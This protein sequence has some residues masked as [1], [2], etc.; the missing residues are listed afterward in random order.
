MRLT[1]KQVELTIIFS[2]IILSLVIL[3]LALL[4]N[5]G[6]AP[7]VALKQ[8]VP[9]SSIQPLDSGTHKEPVKSEPP[10][11]VYQGLLKL[12]G[13]NNVKALV[14]GDSV[15]ESQGATNRE[16]TSWYTLVAN[17]L[18][19]KYPGTVQWE[20]KTTAEAKIHD[21]LNFVPDVPR[22][23]DIIVL[24]VGRYDWTTL[25]TDDF[26]TSYEQV[27]NQLKLN[28][29]N[30]NIFLIVEPPVNNTITNNHFFPY[31]QVIIDLGQKYQLPVINEWTA[32]IND[33]A[34]LAELLANNVNPN[35]K[36]YRLFANEVFK[37]FDEILF[38]K[39]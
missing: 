34:P 22:D 38:P 17:D 15:A 9:T 29:P 18:K 6:Q 13:S 19:A 24:C 30:A 25:T 8:T 4:I 1:S 23:S 39:Y 14:L 3:A 12:V 21:V 37:A 7:K 20:F 31:Y 28:T 2:S 33:P 11:V 36:G 32:F 27:I 5:R 35:D 16:L 10:P 26:K